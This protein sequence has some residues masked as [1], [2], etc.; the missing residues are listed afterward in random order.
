[1]K[2]GMFDEMQYPR[3]W[4]PGGEHQLY[5]EALEQ[6]ELID[7]LGFDSAWAVEHHFLEEYSHCS[8][9][10]VFLAAAAGR[11]RQLRLGHGILQLPVGFTHPAKIAERLATLDLVSD[12]RVEFGS[13][14]GGSRME[15]RSGLPI[16]RPLDTSAQRRGLGHFR[17][18]W[19]PRQPD[20]RALTRW[21]R[22][23]WTERRL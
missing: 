13:G 12:G 3:P 18:H 19:L 15:S 14:E 21:R 4:A 6:I 1:M 10:E 2:F 11:T 20:C 5:R 23:H 8:A 17:C 7:R 16:G 9:P 22:C